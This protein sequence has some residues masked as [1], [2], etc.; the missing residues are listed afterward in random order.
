MS[1]EEIPDSSKF[2]KKFTNF[3]LKIETGKNIADGQSGYRVYPLALVT[4]LFTL[5]HRYEFEVEILARASWAG[6]DITSIPVSV[7][8]NPRGGRISHF[9]PFMDNMR[10]SILNTLLVN[11]R[12]IAW[13][14][15]VMRRIGK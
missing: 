14:W 8:Y 6:V 1:A 12:I 13:P 7:D 9:R 11:I 3:W 5:F 4:K 10:T 15:H 2:G